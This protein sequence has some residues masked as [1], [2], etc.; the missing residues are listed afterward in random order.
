M[1]KWKIWIIKILTKNIWTV[2]CVSHFIIFDLSKIEVQR[3][4]I[5]NYIH[6]L[7]RLNGFQTIEVETI[8]SLLMK[9]FY[10]MKN[11]V[12]YLRLMFIFEVYKANY[13]NYIIFSSK[14]TY[15]GYMIKNVVILKKWSS[16]YQIDYMP[17]WIPILESYYHY[18]GACNRRKHFKWVFWIFLNKFCFIEYNTTY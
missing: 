8:K 12:E 1:W 5:S 4:K 2:E 13:L 7:R 11:P 6:F 10:I 14:A 3:K 17:I 15:E 18:H 16:R 9:S